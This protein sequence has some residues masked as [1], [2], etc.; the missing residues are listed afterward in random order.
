MKQKMY[1]FDVFAIVKNGKRKKVATH[2]YP[3]IKQAKDARTAIERMPYGNYIYQPRE[4]APYVYRTLGRWT[5]S[6]ITEIN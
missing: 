5:C 3:T 1:S 4:N 6:D 2:S